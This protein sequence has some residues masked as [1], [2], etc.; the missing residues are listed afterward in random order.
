MQET[1]ALRDLRPEASNIVRS[2]VERIVVVPDETGKGSTVRLEGDL[3]SLLAFAAS[4]QQN[5]RQAGPDGRST[6][7][8]AGAGFEPA[9]FRL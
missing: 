1:L 3:A 6:K 4:A 9:A 5:A 7:L 8:V 2:L